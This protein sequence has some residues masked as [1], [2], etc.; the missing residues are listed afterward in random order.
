MTVCSTDNGDNLRDNLFEIIEILLAAGSNVNALSSDQA[1]ALI[2]LATYQSGHRDFIKILRLFIQHKVN[3][4]ACDE[5]A[6]NVLHIVCNQ[7][8]YPIIVEAIT[9][10]KA[11][12]INC[13][14]KTKTGDRPVD[15]LKRRSDLKKKNNIIK[16][17][18]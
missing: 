6:W 15:L 18:V 3:L 12:G 17:L 8:K 2:Y 14:Q 16:L 4:N 7:C 5:E 13:N 1:N 10:L 11:N 9:L